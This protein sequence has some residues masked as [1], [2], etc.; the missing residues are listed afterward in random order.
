MYCKTL[1]LWG[2]KKGNLLFF[3]QLLCSL[4]ATITGM[5]LYEITN[6]SMHIIFKT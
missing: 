2:L 6:K 5:Y 3:L 1:L 4:G